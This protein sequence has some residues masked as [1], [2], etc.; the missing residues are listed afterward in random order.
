[1]TANA[2]MK[3]GVKVEE[4]DI[5]RVFLASNV[6]PSAADAFGAQVNNVEEAIKSGD[7]IIDTNVLL[8]PYGTGSA[9]LM[10]IIS[11]YEKLKSSGRIFLPAQVA[12]EFIKNR[13]N[14]IAELQQSL[15]NKVSQ[16]STI[17][18]FSFPIMEDIP[19]YKKLNEL[20]ESAKSIK[21]EITKENSAL[22]A[23]IHSW[24]WSD[25]VSSLYKKVFTSDIIIESEGK[26]DDILQEL[27]RRQRLSIPPGYKDSGKDDLGIGDFLIWKTILKLGGKNKKDI[28]F[29]SGDEKAD[30]QHRAGG[31]GFLPRY[32]LLDEYRRESGGK[33]FYII[34]LSRLLELLKA[35][36][37]SVNEIKQEE[38]R[39]LESNTTEVDCPYCEHTFETKL[40]DLPGSS[41]QPICINCGER[42]HIHRTRHGVTIHKPFE[43]ATLLK[44][45]TVRCPACQ[46]TTDAKLHSAPNSTAN[47]DCSF[48][49]TSFPIHRLPDGGVKTSMYAK[50]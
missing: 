12:R 8:I 31:S 17:D 42:F 30:W 50:S 1:M 26:N 22:I 23:K 5:E 6:L 36:E 38:T 15:L 2:P 48:C 32:E 40:G 10:D 9:S 49:G 35:K 7:I 41:A 39:I 18:K 29:V 28:I 25:P 34:Q 46:N 45:E 47:C 33:A 4:C 3:A 44:H 11:I 19:E 20:I 43:K 37:D 16:I 13:P 24:E 27:L 14:K 21:K